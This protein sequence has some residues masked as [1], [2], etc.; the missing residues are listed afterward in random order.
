MTESITETRAE[1][2]LLDRLGK[3]PD[4]A[5]NLTYGEK[6]IVLDALLT[7]PRLVEQIA[8]WEMRNARLAGMLRRMNLTNRVQVWTAVA[9]SAT[10]TG[11]FAASAKPL[12]GVLAVVWTATAMLCAWFA[13]K[14]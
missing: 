10:Y 8:E 3:L 2:D 7:K 13:K 6:V 12:D 11:W 5:W 1:F 14:P 4:E 9:I